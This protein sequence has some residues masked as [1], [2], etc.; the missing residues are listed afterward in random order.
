MQPGSAET[1]P[2]ISKWILKVPKWSLQMSK[3]TF[4][5]SKWNLRVLT[6]TLEVLKWGL[7]LLKWSPLHSRGPA[8]SMGHAFARVCGGESKCLTEKLWYQHK[9]KNK[10]SPSEQRHPL[11]SEDR[12]CQNVHLR[13]LAYRPGS[14][15]RIIDWKAQGCLAERR[16]YQHNVT[17]IQTCSVHE[18]QT[19]I[20]TRLCIQAFRSFLIVPD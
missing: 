4:K 8:A 16:R 13:P 3:L 15:P 1:G 20:E 14:V 6:W 10:T 5:V 9:V 11:Q 12:R 2:K 18:V 7:K 17:V 19:L